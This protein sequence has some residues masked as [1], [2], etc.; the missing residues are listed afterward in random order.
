MKGGDLMSKDYPNGYDEGY[1]GEYYEDEVFCCSNCG[2]K[3]PEWQYMKYYG[4]CWIC[5]GMGLQQ[6]FP[7]PPGFPGM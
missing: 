3:M 4:L 6:D 7:G 5:R 2:K 1:D